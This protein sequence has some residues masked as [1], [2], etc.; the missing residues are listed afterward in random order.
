MYF[1]EV[2][3]ACQTQS[4]ILIYRK[5]NKALEKELHYDISNELCNSIINKILAW[6]YFKDT[7]VLIHITKIESNL[8]FHLLLI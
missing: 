3:F 4:N 2:I 7:H 8:Y 1:P 5:D 6:I